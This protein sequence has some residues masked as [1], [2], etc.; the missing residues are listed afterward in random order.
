M[1]KRSA[2]EKML[3]IFSALAAIA[4]S[5]FVYL[6]WLNGDMVMASI[7]AA[8]VVVT[9]IFF[10]FV[11]CTR[12]ANTA[13]LAFTIFLSIAI[14]TVVVIRGQSHLFWLYPAI[15]SFY[16]IL[17]VRPA[18]TICFVAIMVIA[19]TL[20][21]TNSTLE[22]LTINFSLFLTAV[23]SYVIF[24]NY[25]KTN[26]KLALLASI[27]PLTSSG[28][29]RALDQTLENIIADQKR[30]AS[31][32]SLLLLDL[33]HFKKINDDYGHA[34][35]DIVLVEL[36]ALI[37]KHSR[38][39]DAL[40]RYGGEEF[41]ILPLK[42]DVTEA[43]QVAEKLRVLIEKTTFADDIPLTVS[44]GIAQYRQGETAEAW[45][46]RADAAL[47]LAKDNGRNCVVAEKTV[48]EKAS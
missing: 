37:Q 40:Y 4:I 7:D 31:N 36:V 39:M 10:V 35:G 27:D 6:R 12:K 38:S 34:N 26:S 19:I 23:F 24:D 8:L 41:I 45:I 30:A 43:K 9:T 13:K 2:S 47:Y 21:P 16:Y 48:A 15:I 11:Y 44:I 3:L 1:T 33:D 25:D 17:P 28:N 14:V 29:R 42:V 22:F 20:F 46:S 32:V 5:P 18:S